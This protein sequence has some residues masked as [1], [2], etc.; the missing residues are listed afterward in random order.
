LV[1]AV[2]GRA[3]DLAAANLGITS[4]YLQGRFDDAAIRIEAPVPQG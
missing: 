4:V 1:T 3:D 2:R